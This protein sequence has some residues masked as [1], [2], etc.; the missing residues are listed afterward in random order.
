MEEK[1]VAYKRFTVRL[2]LP[3]RVLISVV[4]PNGPSRELKKSTLMVDGKAVI[5]ELQYFS[6]VHIP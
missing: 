1:A 3:I 5:R 6:D 4:A 2:S